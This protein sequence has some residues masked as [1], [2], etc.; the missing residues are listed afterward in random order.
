[1]QQQFIALQGTA[2][3]LFHGQPLLGALRS[4]VEAI[5]VALGADAV[6]RRFSAFLNRVSTSA[7]WSGLTAIPML[8]VKELLALFT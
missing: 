8:S 7:P 4:W 6:H 1:M 3:T 2:Q 5:A